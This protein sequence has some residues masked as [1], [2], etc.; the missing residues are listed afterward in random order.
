MEDLKNILEKYPNVKWDSDFNS[1]VIDSDYVGTNP[2]KSP[3]LL[4][5]CVALR[6]ELHLET[7]SDWE[8]S[9]MLVRHFKDEYKLALLKKKEEERLE[10]AR[11]R[12]EERLERDRMMPDWYQRLQKENNRVIDTSYNVVLLFT[13]HPEFKDKLYYNEISKCEEIDGEIINDVIYSILQSKIENMLNRSIKM[14][15]V[16]SG[17]LSYCNEHRRN[18][19]LE[20]FKKLQNDWDGIPRLEEFFIKAYECEDTPYIRY[21]TKVLFFA[22]INRIIKPGC[23][24]DSMFVFEGEQGIGKS[25]LLPRM[26]T[27]IGGR[28]NENMKFN[29]DRNNLEKFA[30]YQLCQSEEL[31]DMKKQD[32]ATIKDLISRNQD[33][34]DRKYRDTKTFKRSCILVGNVNPDEKH[35]LKDLVEYERRFIIFPCNAKGFPDGDRASDKWW[36]EN[37]PDKYLLQVWAEALYKVKTEHDTFRWIS[38]PHDIADELKQ[39]QANYKFTIEDDVFIEK[40]RYV[41]DLGFNREYYD[42]NDYDVFVRDYQDAKYNTGRSNVLNEIDSKLWRVFVDTEL[43][44]KRSKNHFDACM[45]HI[46][47]EFRH[48]TK[49][50]GSKIINQYKYVRIEKVEPKDVKLDTEKSLTEILSLC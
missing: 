27:L 19:L 1:I 25:K 34:F 6:S 32:L 22:W 13:Y 15:N 46:G 33:T 17:V 43:R 14:S 30:T 2:K 37:F 36:Q 3:S 47:W 9:Q 40:M 42:K 28:A 20:N 49:R 44:E 24:F 29:N 31:K 23:N 11:R 5:L 35:F 4:K 7:K 38:L 45:K 39:I 21:A 12:E 26:I 48:S 8:M 10:I 18:P 16:K 50:E 41:L